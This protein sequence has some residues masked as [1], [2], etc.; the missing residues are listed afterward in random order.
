M[1][2][3]GGIILYYYDNGGGYILSVGGGSKK[4]PEKFPTSSNIG[5]ISSTEVNFFKYQ[6]FLWKN[7]FG[8]LAFEIDPLLKEELPAQLLASQ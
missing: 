8:F 1:I 5:V 3:G 7:S 4:N 2:R 6:K